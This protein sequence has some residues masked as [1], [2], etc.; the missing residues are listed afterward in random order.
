LPRLQKL[1]DI[2]RWQQGVNEG[3]LSIYTLAKL[4]TS[5]DHPLGG[6]SSD[7]AMLFLL[8]LCDPHLLLMRAAK[9]QLETEEFDGVGLEHVPNSD[10]FEAL[11]RRG[12]GRATRL[13]KI[14]M[15]KLLC[16]NTMRVPD[17]AG[18]AKGYTASYN[19]GK[20]FNRM[21][22]LIIDNQFTDFD[23]TTVLVHT[24]I[25][26][27]NPERLRMKCIAHLYEQVE[28]KATVVLYTVGGRTEHVVTLKN[29]RAVYRLLH[30]LML[31]IDEAMKDNSQ[32][33]DHIVVEPFGPPHI[34]KEYVDMMTPPYT[35][36]APTDPK[37]GKR[38]WNDRERRGNWKKS[39]KKE[40]SPPITASPPK[41][42]RSEFGG[43][44]NRT[45]GAPRTER[46]PRPVGTPRVPRDPT[47]IACV[48][49]DV[50]GHK[51]TRCPT[52]AK[53]TCGAP[54]KHPYH[55]PFRC[56]KGPLTEVGQAVKTKWKKDE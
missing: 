3:L 31:T 39:D 53:C 44:V 2:P 43:R 20:Y 28:A 50:N 33:L 45:D 12:L 37:S 6:M 8:E 18:V 54:L 27:I 9:K 17:Y 42:P 7:E 34:P 51:A 21:D 19:L 56:P 41:K 32:Y 40:S 5:E 16:A 4:Q 30:K 10:I 22:E 48:L 35:T 15:L 46:T 25:S 24:F 47:T 13:N 49:C 26:G 55:D 36:T 14:G 52:H 23:G 11:Q 1:D 29:C 38:T